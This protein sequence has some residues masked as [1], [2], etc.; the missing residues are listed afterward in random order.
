[1][2]E[3]LDLAKEFGAVPINGADQ[4]SALKAIKEGTE[5]RGVDCALEAVGAQPTIKLAFDIIRMGGQLPLPCCA[6]PCHAMPYCAAVL[7][8][9]V[10]CCAVLCCA[11]PCHAVPCRAVFRRVVLCYGCSAVLKCHPVRHHEV[12]MQSQVHQ[13]RSR[14]GA[15]H[16]KEAKHLLI[17]IHYPCTHLMLAAL[18][19]WMHYSGKLENVHILESKIHPPPSPPLP[20]HR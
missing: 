15:N 7:C 18:Q 6:V 5:G 4:E 13:T 16:H 2:Q 9:A 3:R 12:C 20:N 11:V 1:M 17:C 10:P 19:K 14:L 8:C